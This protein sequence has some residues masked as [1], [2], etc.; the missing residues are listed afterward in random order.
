MKNI[1]LILLSVIIITSCTDN[2]KT[3]EIEGTIRLGHEVRAFTDNQDKKEYWLIDKSGNLEK[4]YQK[5]IGS[6]IMNYRPV[7]A[8]LT[9]QDLG[10]IKEG[11]AA[12]YD[13]TYEV[14]KIISLTPI[15]KTKE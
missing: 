9:V 8:K 10:K 1:C 12:E 11:F 15:S 2:S 4:A 7:K 3:K 6:N 5:A 13:G 14:Q